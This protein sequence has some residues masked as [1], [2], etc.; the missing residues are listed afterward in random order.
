M[1]TL[2]VLSLPF[3]QSRIAN[4][5]AAK[6][7]QNYST[8]IRVDGVAVSSTGSIVLK[9][10]FIADHHADTLFYAKN[11]QTDLYSFGKW[12]AGDLF[13]DTAAF[14]DVYLKVIRYDGEAQNSLAYFSEQLL[15]HLA[16]RDRDPAF[17]RLNQLK[18]T[19]GRFSFTENTDQKQPIKAED[20]NLLATDFFVIDKHIEIDLEALSFNANPFGKLDFLKSQVSINPCM[21]ELDSFTIGIEGSLFAG[22]LK[23]ETP[24]ATVGFLD[25]RSTLQIQLQKGRLTKAFLDNFLPISDSFEPV[26]FSFETDGFLADLKLT[27]L[28][29][30]NPYVNLAAEINIKGGFSEAFPQI[31]AKIDRFFTTPQNLSYF[32]TRPIMDKI[33]L[34]MFDYDQIQMFGNTTYKDQEWS[35]QLNISIDDGVIIQKGVVRLKDNKP[36]RYAA[37]FDIDQFNLNPWEERLGNI[38]AKLSLTANQFLSDSINIAYDLKVSQFFFKKKTFSNLSIEGAYQDKNFSSNIAIADTQIS[39]VSALAFSWAEAQRKYQLDLNVAHLNLKTINQGLGDDKADFSGDLTLFLVGN[40]LDEIQGNLLFKNLS[41]EN[42]TDTYGYNDFIIETKLIDGFR[43]LKTINSNLF[44]FDAS[45][46]FL[47]SA[48][49][50]LFQNAIAQVYS[51]IP[52]KKVKLGQSLNYDLSIPSGNLNPFFP[53]LTMVDNAIF[54]GVLSAD[55]RVSKLVVKIPKI[56]Y[57]GIDFEN[58]DFQLDNQ[59]PFFNTYLTIGKLAAG[60]IQIVD[61]NTLSKNDNGGL[62]FRTEFKGGDQQLKEFELNYS[63]LLKDQVSVFE[64]KKS[65]GSIGDNRWLINPLAKSNHLFSYDN[66]TKRFR[67]NRFEAVSSN[68]KLTF[69]MSYLNNE[70]YDIQLITDKVSIENLG[71]PYK[72]FD[73]KGVLDLGVNIKRSLSNNTLNVDGVVQDFYLNDL[74]MGALSFNTKGNTQLNAYDID[75]L[76]SNGGNTP[77]SGKGNLLDLD[78]KPLLDLDLK[79][80][81]F[82]LSFLSPIGN[83]AIENIRGKVSGAV[84]L[85]GAIN[86]PQHN[87]QLILNDGGLAVTEVNTDYAIAAGTRVNLMN[88]T[89]DFETTAFKDV[90]FDT[91]GQLSG[92]IAHQNFKEWNFD[93]N[94][95]SDR[96][97]MLNI[98]EDQD[99]VFFGDGFLGGEVK[100]YGPSKNLTIDV[101]GSTEE[102][103]SIKIPWSKDYGLADTSFIKYVDKK[104]LNDSNYETPVTATNFRGLEMNF[105]L[106]VNNKAE[107]GVVIDKESGSYLSGRGAGNILM[108][109]DTN[110][111]FNMWGDFITFDG[112]YNFKNLSVIDKKFNLKQGG[113]IVWEGDPLSAQMD[114]EAV[115]VVPGGANPALLLDN[116]NFN[117]KIPT[118]VLIRLQGNLLKPDDPIFEIDFPNTNAV[119]TSEINY[120]L[121][122]PQTSQLQA[123]S[124][125]SQ[126]IFI[127]EVSLSVQGITNNLYEKASDLFSNIMGNDQGK[128]Q[129]GINYLQGD[130][131]QVL[132]VNSEDRLGLTLSTQITDK[133]LI[134]GKIGVPVGGLEETLIVGDLQIDFILNEEGSL[135]AKV[136]NKENEFRYIGDELGYT[137]GLGLSYRVDF[138]TFKELIYKI[139]NGT[140]FDKITSNQPKLDTPSEAGINF[141]NKN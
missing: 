29:A 95:I 136:F 140:K 74:S 90:K 35:S 14:N 107:I 68:E 18:I 40:S 129:V 28:N 72:N 60:S 62:L 9:S 100:L 36:D 79:F 101:V 19:D 59:N 126:G 116:P 30:S 115:Y 1:L 24:D 66:T 84:N 102:G 51:F 64:L 57:K 11:F 114:L 75:L 27:D 108:E 121:S 6:I 87:G 119:V 49:P 128:L 13:F 63:Y 25:D 20:I 52:K 44:D 73:V 58:I 42:S 88:Q 4:K 133:I 43:T 122:D 56:R 93:F 32:L 127:N 92:K 5:I 12:A 139:I 41:F 47:L 78:K 89:F 112:I 54:R 124:L 77:L 7:N 85:S 120:R 83:G 17:V 15:S 69:S 104:K 38:D 96:I 82:D 37:T 33:P 34:P 141:V 86:S 94:I 70:D 10:F 81:Q 134:N 48:F 123:I 135:K 76:L 67:I 53:E 2:V 113:T 131:N 117:R 97:L 16:R 55:E 91:Q 3:V 103:S 118:E 105:E 26:D 98:P 130:N 23:L 110:G 125:L 21:I 138:E 50:D 137:Q 8:A 99:A 71:F 132:D 46:E 31:T 22:D 106:D 65:T 45:G 80:D 39:A 111:K 61:F 109:I